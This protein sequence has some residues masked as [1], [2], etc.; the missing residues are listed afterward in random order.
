MMKLRNPFWIASVVTIL[1]LGAGLL[2]GRLVSAQSAVAS[3]SVP[4]AHSDSA[5]VVPPVVNA[6]TKITLKK[7]PELIVTGVN[8]KMKIFWQYKDNTKFRV[9][10]GIDATYS[11]GHATVSA[12]DPTNHLFAYTISGLTPGKKYTYRVVVG[13]NY[14]AGTFFTAPAATATKMK[15]LSY[16]DTRTNPSTH[17]KVAGQVVSLYKSD[18]AFQT[19]NP[20]VGDLVTS[21]ESETYWGKEFYA[22]SM[23]NLR[24]EMAN[25]MVIPVIGNHEG[26][27]KLFSRYFP[28]PYVA[29]RYFSFDYGPAHFTYIDQYNSYSSGSAQ[30]NWIKADLAKSTKKWKFVVLH[31]PGWSAGGH[32]NNTKVQKTLQP[33]FEKYGVSIVFGGH[34]HYYSRAVVNGVQHL[35]IGTGGAPSRAPASGQSK[36]VK[37]VKGTGYS[38]FVIDGS[39][40]TSTFI[41]STGKVRDTFTIKK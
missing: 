27:G 36:I 15:F 40:L 26:D 4:A 10:W 24:A 7:G 11:L 9:D 3:V 41:D 19:L 13:T 37:T 30:Y 31:E 22:S 2:P 20:M 25:M 1:A 34:N 28:L 14:S 6:L 33:L 12:Y 38:K 35:T 23:T 32:A 17:D 5:A 18:P 39:T 21:G 8:T 29:K 16:G